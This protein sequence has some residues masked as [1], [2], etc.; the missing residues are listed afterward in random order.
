MSA[1]QKMPGNRHGQSAIPYEVGY[2]RP[3]VEH[4]FRKGQSGNPGGR[5]K[6]A[7]KNPVSLDPVARPT[8]G[9]ILEEAYRSVTIREGERII[10]LPAIQAAVRSLAIAAM[11]GSR[12]SQKALAEIVREVENRRSAEHLSLLENALEYKMKWTDELERRKKSGLA[13]PDPI[14]HPEDIIIDMRTGH[15]RT[16]GP[17]DEREKAK[18]DDMLA[19]RAEAQDEV[20]NAAG[21][22]ARARD[23]RKKEMWLSEW[24]SEQHIFDII[25][26][27]LP[28]RYKMK[29]ENRSYRAGASRPGKASELLHQKKAQL[30][31]YRA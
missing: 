22:Y 24:H 29:L 3:P 13:L 9:L 4:R 23:E 11:K 17:V 7:G 1:Q 21:K 15:V 28:E 2:G 27:V 19:R 25:N 12:L 30:K 10:E 8:D 16:E 26:D 18:W 5:P 31:N 20:T 14:P 6:K